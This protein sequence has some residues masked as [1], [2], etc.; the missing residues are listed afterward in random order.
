L[1]FEKQNL[2]QETKAIFEIWEVS[3][4]YLEVVFGVVSVVYTI[5]PFEI[6]VSNDTLE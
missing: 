3:S 5:L 1:N 4:T 6:I 2:T